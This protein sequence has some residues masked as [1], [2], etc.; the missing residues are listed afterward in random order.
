MYQVIVDA[1]N[2]TTGTINVSVKRDTT[3]KDGSNY[4]SMF[5]PFNAYSE[6]ANA[7]SQG[8]LSQIIPDYWKISFTGSTGG[9]NNIH[10][11]GSLRIC[12]QQVYPSTGG[13]ASGFSA[14]DEAYGSTAPASQTF[15]TGDIYM[16]LAGVP[17][18]LWVAALTSSSGISTA[19][20]AGGNKFVSVK[21]VDN[22]DGVCGT[23][24]S[25]TCNS[26]CVGKSAVESG[27]SQIMTYANSDQ[28]AKLSSSFTLNSAYKNLIAVMRE[29]TNSS[30]SA[31]T[32]T[33]A[34]CSADSFSVRPTAVTSLTSSNA[35]GA[36]TFKA[37]GDNFALTATTVNAAGSNA[38]GYT[39][40]LKINNAAVQAI[41]PATAIGQVSPTQIGPAISG[42]AT[43]SN[44]T[45][46]EV[47]AF[48]ILQ[49]DPTSTE[50]DSNKKPRGVYDGV[51]TATE[52]PSTSITTQQCDDLRAAT[53]TGVDSITTE[54]DC[55]LD[56]FSNTK[57]ATGKYGC[58]FGLTADSANFGR[59]IPNH[60]EISANSIVNRSDTTCTPTASSF[61]YM[62]EPFKVN[63]TLTAMNAS[64]TKTVN[65]ATGKH[66]NF[67]PTS[68]YSLGSNNS[69]GLWMAASD[70][71]L[72][73]GTCDVFFSATTPFSTSF[74]CSG[75]GNPAAI[76]RAAGSR[77]VV[78]STLPTPTWT[79]GVA[80]I[81]ADVILHRADLPDG[82]YSKLKVGIAPRDADGVGLLL[83]A[84][85]EDLKLDA[86]NDGVQERALLGSTDV[87]YGRLLIPNIY[88]SH[89]LPLP[90]PVQAQYW[91]GPTGTYVFN[92]ADSCTLLAA[93]SFTV[94]AGAGASVSTN[95]TGGGTMVGG[96][97][98]L[99]FTAPSP[100]PTGSGSKVLSTSTISPAG[101]PLNSYLPGKGV[102]TFGVYKAGPVIYFRERY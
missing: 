55:I 60:F 66:A 49:L 51:L 13:I 43:S 101:L 96:K 53:W 29:C 95:L 77:V 32:T 15:Q 90:V 11:I 58:N 98:T 91:N 26:S 99:M 89:M 22:S 86:D 97:G 14:I 39:G 46:S 40:T 44:I 93:S 94:A 35:T 69:F 30:C 67:S 41:S 76:A 5:G 70:Y 12:A 59:F 63:F 82:A 17:F 84:M 47:G 33:A 7:V 36:S 45:Y 92:G 75:V 10:E 9:S 8:W 23:D 37:G 19:Y 6:A 34:A 88:G 83:P 79:N 2:S 68:W 52:C 62:G 20:A 4:V 28:G 27:G 65:Y 80:Q 25:R 78:T 42:I 48:R 102:E 57:D 71:A 81:A 3:T 73:S 100:A 87:R 24:A 64:N 38:S 56:S 85:A 54:G 21:L 72:G 16:K 50:S 1:R 61:T 31:F 18:K 74:D